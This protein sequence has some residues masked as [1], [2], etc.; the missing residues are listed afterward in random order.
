MGTTRP[1]FPPLLGRRPK[2]RS[3]H[4]WSPPNQQNAKRNLSSNLTRA[5][6]MNGVSKSWSS[7]IHAHRTLTTLQLTN[8]VCFA[9]IPNQSNVFNAGPPPTIRRL[10]SPIKAGPH[11]S[12]LA[13][14]LALR[15]LPTWTQARNHRRPLRCTEQFQAIVFVLSTFINI[16]K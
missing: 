16:N 2:L 11:H 12:K 13:L 7:I 10:P 4:F 9:L 5:E 15:W 14:K 1:L 6:I 3:K 8:K